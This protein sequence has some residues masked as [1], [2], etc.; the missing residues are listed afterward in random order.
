VTPYIGQQVTIRYT[1]TETLGGGT[2]TSFFDDDNALNV[3]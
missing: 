3:S 1:G 2:N